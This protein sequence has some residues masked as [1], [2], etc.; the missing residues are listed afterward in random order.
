VLFKKPVTDVCVASLPSSL[1][2]DHTRHDIYVKLK[3]SVKKSVSAAKTL[4]A[5]RHYD[6][7]TKGNNNFRWCFST[8]DQ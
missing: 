1:G 4:Y 7:W 8:M 5:E 6:K 3:D 2:K